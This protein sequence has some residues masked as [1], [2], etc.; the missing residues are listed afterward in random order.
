MR[1]LSQYIDHTNLK[2]T[3]SKADIQ[4]LCQEAVSFDM[5]S[6][7]IHPCHV[8]F[9][10]DC[11]QGTNVK[12]CTVIGFP[13]GATL[14]AVKRFEAEQAISQGADE[15]DMV[16]NIGAL[17]EGCLDIVKQDIAA[18]VAAAQG[19]IVKVIIETGLLSDPEKQLAVELAC[20]AG[21]NYVKTCTGFSSGAATVDD[22]RLMKQS[23]AS[24]VLVK[25][26]GGIRDRST[27]MALIDAGADRLGTSSGTVILAEQA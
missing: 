23:C 21:A 27:A 3:A 25:A 13:L 7:C 22:V 6:V 5:A 18:V 12:V 17:K 20:E 2:P 4:R 16:I 14:T 8:S 1:P 26:S 15:L 24:G 11:L 19:R 9:A 10:K